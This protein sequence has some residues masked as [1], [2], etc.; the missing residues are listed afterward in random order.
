MNGATEL[1]KN[2]I[3]S[4][5]RV[6]VACAPAADEATILAAKALKEVLI[7]AGKKVFLWPEPNDFFKEKFQKI[8]SDDTQPEI[9]QKIKIKIPKSAPLEELRYEDEGEFLSIIVS[10]KEKLDPASLLIEKAPYEMDAAFL[11]LD[12]TEFEKIEAPVQTPPRDKRVY[13]TNNSRTLAEKIK[14]IHETVH[15]SAPLKPETATLLFAS[16]A[17]ETEH[18]RKNPTAAA[19]NLTGHLISSGADP[20][21][22]HEIFSASEDLG[23]AQLLGRALARTAIE[24]ELKISWT[25]LTQK[26]FEKTKIAPEEKILLSLLQKIR[27]VIAAEPLAV[28]CYQEGV[29]VRT[30]LSSQDPLIL[31]RLSESMGFEAKGSYFFGPQFKNFSEAETRTRELLKNAVRDKIK[32]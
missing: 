2:L 11:F 26:D 29:S 22:I 13:L 17:L 15:G 27:R 8:L 5:S 4:S 7:D 9:P 31:S 28:L 1:I 25:F 10:P 18:F 19:F 16:L 32:E 12:E 20:K 14:E 30:L 24:K 23:S 6:L 3:N 21:T